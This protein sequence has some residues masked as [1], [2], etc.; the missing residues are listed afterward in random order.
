MK[1]GLYTLHHGLD[2]IHAYR[3]NDPGRFCTEKAHSMSNFAGL[4]GGTSRAPSEAARYRQV[5]GTGP[6]VTSGRSR[7]PFAP[8]QLPAH[9]FE[10]P[11]S[12]G[13]CWPISGRRDTGRGAKPLRGLY[14]RT[15]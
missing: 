15:A 2:A 1:A 7:F 9:A 6:A 12:L 11:L 13:L 4:A 5:F 3:P 14:E 10:N 8:F